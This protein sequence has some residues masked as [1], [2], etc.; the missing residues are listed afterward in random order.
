MTKCKV[1]PFAFGTVPAGSFVREKSRFALYSASGAAPARVVA[2]ELF[3]AEA[4]DLA[5]D[6]L[7]AGD[8]L[9][10]GEVR[11]A[12]EVFCAGKVFFAD[13]LLAEL[14]FDVGPARR[15]VG[16]LTRWVARVELLVRLV[17]M[18]TEIARS[19]P[20]RRRDDEASRQILPVCAT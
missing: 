3:F 2:R 9:V 18:L 1:F 15:F 10:A 8:V 14:R 17:A 12:D 11:F 16:E 7:F 5:V 19:M 4:V 20:G 6:V 13:A